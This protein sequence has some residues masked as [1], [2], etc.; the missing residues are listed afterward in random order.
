MSLPEMLAPGRDEAGGC[1]TE[2]AW[3]PSVGV[4]GTEEAGEADSTI[5]MRWE[6]VATSLATVWANVEDG[7]T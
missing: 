1:P 4:A 2:E 7:L 5:H 3:G 6:R